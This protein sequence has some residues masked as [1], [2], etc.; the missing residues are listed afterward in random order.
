MA[1]ARAIGVNHV[2]AQPFSRMARCL[3]GEMR[4]DMLGVIDAIEGKTP[5]TACLS[6]SMR[7]RKENWWQATNSACSMR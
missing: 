4:P 1:L 6:T 5:S 2:E 3:D 7:S